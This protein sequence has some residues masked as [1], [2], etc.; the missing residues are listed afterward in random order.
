[1]YLFF[2]NYSRFFTSSDLVERIT[3]NFLDY[4]S[5]IFYSILITYFFLEIFF[6]S[7][8][9]IRNA[10]L[11]NNTK[12][13]FTT[14]YVLLII[15]FFF[16]DSLI[17]L[18]DLLII[19]DSKTP[20]GLETNIFETILSITPYNIVFSHLESILCYLIFK[21]ASVVASSYINKE[22]E[23]K[24][25][26]SYKAQSSLEKIAIASK[27]KV[28]TQDFLYTFL[29]ENIPSNYY[30]FFSSLVV[31]SKENL[32]K[33]Y[34]KY[35]LIFEY[36]T[37]YN[38]Y[39]S[40]DFLEENY[41]KWLITKQLDISLPL[42]CLKKLIRIYESNKIKI[43]YRLAIDKENEYYVFFHKKENIESPIREDLL[44]KIGLGI[45]YALFLLQSIKK[46]ELYNKLIYKKLNLEENINL[47]QKLFDKNYKTLNASLN[48]IQ[49]TLT[50][51]KK[52]DFL[53][54]SNKDISQ[55]EKEFLKTHYKEQKKSEKKELS[56]SFLQKPYEQ[57]VTTGKVAVKNNQFSYY[58]KLPFLYEQKINRNIFLTKVCDEVLLPNTFLRNDKKF[59]LSL[60]ANSN[61]QILI[62][63]SFKA[64]SFITILSLF[65]KKIEYEIS[66]LS[67]DQKDESQYE[68]LFSYY[69]YQLHSKKHYI[70]FITGVTER[71]QE[72][73]KKLIMT[74]I[75]LAIELKIN[76]KK[77]YIII[78]SIQEAHLIHKSIYQYSSID[79]F[80]SQNIKRENGEDI[81]SFIFHYYKQAAYEPPKK[82][83]FFT[84]I[85]EHT[86]LKNIY[87]YIDFF[88]SYKKKAKYHTTHREEIES[89]E[90]AITLGKDAL[91]NKHLM[92]TLKK[93]YK[94][95]A[96]IAKLLGVHKST[97]TR[98]FKKNTDETDEEK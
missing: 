4:A 71:N 98:F 39:I 28:S 63:P 36:I 40:Y 38:N 7:F 1:M 59:F 90:E 22:T 14:L 79:Y 75:S 27:E 24:I 8:S 55:K 17:L 70:F 15:R 10:P 45:K 56:V 69:L 66:F 37:S 42:L 72:Y 93:M 87:H 34:K 49:I 76:I 41:Q 88:D 86:P 74:Y 89:K 82:E 11:K 62:A 32:Q 80:H 26:A 33:K 77:I 54:F 67:L 35:E 9:F 84:F 5:V 60:V 68:K 47:Q 91:K 21:N 44:K 92:N 83:T 3:S 52:R 58:I 30:S 53:F 16:Y 13:L 6:A 64:K 48:N 95:S 61:I 65:A 51:K 12:F 46:N 78:D 81:Y 94:Y 2:S 43:V 97:V 85:K 19:L 23:K 57:T 73:Q 96:T 29:E 25:Y 20:Y 50:T 31:V 18:F